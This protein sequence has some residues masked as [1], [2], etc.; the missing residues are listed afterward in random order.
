MHTYI[1]RLSDGATVVVTAASRARAAHLAM[2]DSPSANW[3]I[4][5]RIRQL[6]PLPTEIPFATHQRATRLVRESFARAHAL[7]HSVN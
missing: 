3:P 4:V 5:T 7:Q 6:H 2:A 1:I